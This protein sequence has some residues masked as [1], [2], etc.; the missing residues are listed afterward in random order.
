MFPLDANKGDYA[1]KINPDAC[2]AS[3]ST[4]AGVP[5]VPLDIEHQPLPDG[6]DPR[7]WSPARKFLMVVMLSA[8]SWIPASAA[9]II[10]PALASVE[11]D[12][13]TNPS[14]LAL[15]VSIFILVQGGGSMTFVPIS[16]LYGR[17][18]IYLSCLLAFTL[19]QVGAGRANSIGQFIA[20]RVIG[21]YASSPLLTMAAGTI[22]DMYEVES[23]GRVL[24]LYYCAPLL[25][26]SM[27]A[28]GGALTSAGSWRITFYFLAACG[29]AIL[30]CYILF[31]RETF[32]KERSLVWQK[33]H[34]RAIVEAMA[35]DAKGASQNGEVQRQIP[36][37]RTYTI[38]QLWPIEGCRD[39][40][41]KNGTL[42]PISS[43]TRSD[44]K[45]FDSPIYLISSAHPRSHPATRKLGTQLGA[46]WSG[47]PKVHVDAGV[48]LRPLEEHQQLQ[49]ES[50][51]PAHHDEYD[52]GYGHHEYHGHT[53]GIS[54]CSC[55]DLHAA[56]TTEG[57][58]NVHQNELSKVV[59]NSQT[60]MPP[61]AHVRS[62]PGA[63][64]F[65]ALTKATSGE[66][67][68]RLKRST[69]KNSAISISGSAVNSLDRIITTDGKEI[70]VRVHASDVNPLLPMFGIIQQP[71]NFLTLTFSGLT[72]GSQYSL[73]FAASRTFGAAP[74][75]F[76][77]IKVGLVL[78]SLGA[79]GMIGSICGG[80]LS[81]RNLMRK[82]C[83]TGHPAPAE[84]R[85]MAVRLL[86]ILTPLM[87]VAYAWLV[88]KKVNVAGPVIVLF[89]L[90][91]V[92][93]GAY[94]SVLS[95]LVDANKGRAAA[96]VSTNSVYRGAFAC[97]ASQI[98]G[99]LQDRMGDGWF[100]TGWA[101][102]LALAQAMLFL[103]AYRGNAWRTKAAARKA[104]AEQKA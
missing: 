97:V 43:G 73:S 31:F 88:D 95:Y 47:G 45:P 21:G 49:N 46:V 22:A 6:N 18:W 11:A 1:R 34:K 19:A 58:L 12:L 29:S 17:K 33:A 7:L 61:L 41:K 87:F 67:T 57:L 50:S 38:R 3:S 75:H 66:I 24:G 60:K 37:R 28:L 56:F 85:L 89:F 39:V 40:G 82:R 64:T 98:A 55:N 44:E 76:E 99:P 96:A 51:L 93:F 71:H 20:M 16:E 68:G 100:N 72:F 84:E 52:H 23:R 80:R 70:K 91:F 54:S 101:V 14:V 36:S 94:S 5:A 59:E 77:P 4:T 92:Q 90:G 62:A 103:V 32:R 15:S 63:V 2:H 10:F 25:G 53:A 35:L 74:Y 13:R 42:H 81:D 78:F 104:E 9:N 30:L 8:G 26:P 69:T 48:G 86:C 102:V 79:G 27:G 65:S 83:A